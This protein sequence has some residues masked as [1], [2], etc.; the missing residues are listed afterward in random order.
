MNQR[1]NRSQII[2]NP[3]L[4]LKENKKAHTRSTKNKEHTIEAYKPNRSDI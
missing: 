2:T 1:T 3:K 4:N